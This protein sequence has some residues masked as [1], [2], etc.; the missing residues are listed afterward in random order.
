[1]VGSRSLGTRRGH[2]VREEFVLYNVQFWKPNINIKMS[3]QTMHNLFF[4]MVRWLIAVLPYCVR[5]LEFC[6]H[7]F[8]PVFGGQIK[9]LLSREHSLSTPQFIIFAYVNVGHS[10]KFF[11]DSK[12]S[13][14]QMKRL[15]ASLKFAFFDFL[16]KIT[17]CLFLY[18]NPMFA[19]VF[20]SCLK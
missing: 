5:N 17:P 15:G 4:D 11:D 20:G 7:Q 3:T 1:M 10:S 13:P 19:F 9:S 14:T 6:F 18:R 8:P 12:S 16:T 2:R